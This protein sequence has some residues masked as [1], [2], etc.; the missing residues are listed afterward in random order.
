VLKRK[1]AAATEERSLSFRHC[2]VHNG[3]GIP[4]RKQK[5]YLHTNSAKYYN[6]SIT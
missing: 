1:I 3:R 4:C 5:V 2:Q 6:W